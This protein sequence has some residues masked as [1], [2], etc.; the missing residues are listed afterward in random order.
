MN[1][2]P[3]RLTSLIVACALV[4]CSRAQPPDVI[5]ILID[6]W[7]W[8]ALGSNTAAGP[9]L[10]PH[11]DALAERG[12]RFSR[13]YS[14]APWTLP[15]A[16]SLLTGRY[17]TVHG[18]YGR[19]PSRFNEFGPI[20]PDVPTLAELLAPAGYRTRAVVNAPFLGWEFGF[21]RGFESYDLVPWSPTKRRRAEPAVDAA[22]G[23]IRDEPA[24][25]PLFLLLHLF[26]PHL[27]YD[28]PPPWD[29]RWTGDYRGVLQPPVDP[30]EEVRSGIYDPDPDDLAY[31]RGLYHGEVSY[32]DEQL[33]RFLSELDRLA[34][35]R[36]RLIIVTADHGEEFGEHGGWEHGHSVYRELVQV[37][38]ILVPPDSWRIEAGVVESQVVQLDLFPT[39]LEAAGVAPP[40][41]VPGRSLLSVMRQRGALDHPAYSERPS[42]GSPSVALRDGRHTLVLYFDDRAPQLYDGSVDAV[43]ASDI[44]GEHP[45]RVQELRSQ[46]VELRA[47]LDRL[48]AAMPGAPLPAEL[49]PQLE[50]QLHSLGY[51]DD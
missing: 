24:G 1:S 31:L 23:I 50:Q 35:E 9:D 2:R 26:D 14:T 49:D 22:L 40:G 25:K 7:R 21:D 8:D 38:L 32:A 42:L 51:I 48:V 12:V 16:A 15:A 13:A 45:E 27:P 20:R 46:A 5:L 4:A 29:R 18:A 36:E 41:P 30:L 37:P 6:T 10:T 17:P 28:P 3:G 39:V 44:A 43:E 34:P 19:E 11:L 33:G 47:A